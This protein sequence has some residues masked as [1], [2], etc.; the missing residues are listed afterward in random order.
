[1]YLSNGIRLLEIYSEDKGGDCLLLRPNLPGDFVEDHFYKILDLLTT[2]VTTQRL[3]Y[4]H[5]GPVNKIRR[6]GTV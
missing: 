6:V 4:R 3:A 1:M 5:D 2:F